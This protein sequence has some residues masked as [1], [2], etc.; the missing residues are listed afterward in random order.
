MP[1]HQPP[2][3]TTSTMNANAVQ[4][5]LSGLLLDLDPATAR[6]IATNALRLAAALVAIAETTDREGYRSGA[7]EILALL[8][9]GPPPIPA[10]AL[11]QAAA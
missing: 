5:A 3:G 8:T 11:D 6:R 10:A 9:E 1:R 7:V 2:A 4:R